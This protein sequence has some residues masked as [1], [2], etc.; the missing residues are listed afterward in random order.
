MGGAVRCSARI[1]RSP[2]LLPTALQHVCV[3]HRRTH[4]L[5]PQECSCTVRISHP[6]SDRCVA[7]LCWH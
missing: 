2:Y 4:V 3:D 1:E 6:S 7:K 5:M